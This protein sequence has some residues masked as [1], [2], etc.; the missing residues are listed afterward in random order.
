MVLIISIV[1]QTGNRF[2]FLGNSNL[3]ITWPHNL[4]HAH[5]DQACKSILPSLQPLT[6]NIRSSESNYS[7]RASF[8]KI[9][10]EENKSSII[11]PHLC[12]LEE[13]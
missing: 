8:H 12:M 5:T 7:L 6:E 1:L 10:H 9:S 3:S 11:L 2:P 4:N 13:R